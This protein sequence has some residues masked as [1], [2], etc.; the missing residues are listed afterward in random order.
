[1]KFGWYIG[2]IEIPL[3]IAFGKISTPVVFFSGGAAA[4]LAHP[5]GTPRSW[6]PRFISSGGFIGGLGLFM[7]RGHDKA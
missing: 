5:G 4:I 2:L 3:E 1:M 6:I 7:N